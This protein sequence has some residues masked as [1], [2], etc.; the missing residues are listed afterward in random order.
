MCCQ[1]NSLLLKIGG[2]VNLLPVRPIQNF[3]DLNADQHVNFRKPLATY[4]KFGTKRNF[5]I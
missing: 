4:V 5:D 2:F 1:E 3:A